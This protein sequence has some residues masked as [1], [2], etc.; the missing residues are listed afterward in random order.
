MK[1]VIR[2][3]VFILLF[4]MIVP[5]CYAVLCT[6]GLYDELVEKSKKIEATHS[7]DQIVIKNVD[8]DIMVKYN[9]TFYEPVNGEITIEEKNEV[10][11]IGLY[12][13][14]D[15]DCVEELLNTIPVK[16]NKNNNYILIF[17]TLAVIA[18]IFI[19]DYKINSNK[20]G[21]KGKNAKK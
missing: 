5:N 6:R 4:L 8:K 19:I 12:A 13:G 1:I 7:N 17:L 14:Y 18:I 15:T 2:I 20:K 16:E 21:K 10:E 9:G 11:S 3:F